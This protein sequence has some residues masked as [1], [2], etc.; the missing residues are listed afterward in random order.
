[1]AEIEKNGADALRMALVIG[2]AAGQD[3]RLSDER[4]LA[5]KHLVNKL[6]NTAK[7][8]ER[9]LGEAPAAA[10]ADFDLATVAHPLNRWMVARAEGLAAEAKA[11]LEAYAFGDVAETL[12]SGFWTE[13]CDFYLEAI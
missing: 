12:R 4:I 1:Q 3:F 6:W 13:F 11:R 9:T 5:C 2:N 7:L 10:P 8:V